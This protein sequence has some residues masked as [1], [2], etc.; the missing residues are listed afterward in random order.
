MEL[1]SVQTENGPDGRSQR[2]VFIDNGMVVI[3]TSY[4]KG[5]SAGKKAKIIHRYRPREIGELIVYSMWLLEPWVKQLQNMVH[6]QTDF[7]PFM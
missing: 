1:I 6:G 7:S 2:G 4:H 3:V 5:W